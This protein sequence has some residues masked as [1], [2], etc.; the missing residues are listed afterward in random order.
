MYGLNHRRW[1]YK[2]ILQ[3]ISRTE[4]IQNHSQNGPSYMYDKDF[5]SLSISS[6]K[7]TF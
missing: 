7:N 3:K 2:L 6:L 5:P 1:F 4:R